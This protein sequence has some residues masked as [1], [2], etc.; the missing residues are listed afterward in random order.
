LNARIGQY[1]ARLNQEPA[2]EQ[3]MADLTRGY[4]QSKTNYDELL[5][6]ESD[7]RMATSMEELQQGERFTILDPPSLPL[8]PTFPNRLKM[9]GLGFAVGTILGAL[10]VGILE[11]LDDRLH[12]DKGIKKQLPA[13]IIS[14]VPEILTENDKHRSARKI[15]YGWAMAALVLIC[16]LAGTAFSYLQS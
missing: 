14:E 13:A 10:V 4:E 7:S 6:K 8:K 12:S 11:L 15:V 5:K 2:S 16:I 1:Q 9:C 3:Q